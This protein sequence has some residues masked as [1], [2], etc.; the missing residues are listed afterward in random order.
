MN[1]DLDVDEAAARWHMAQDDDAMDWDGFTRW[2][3]ADPR[4]RTAFDAIALLD[5]KIDAALPDLRRIMPP[6]PAVPARRVRPLRWAIGGSAVA[7]VA[8]LGLIFL[9]GT[10]APASIEYRTAQG[11][12]RDVQLADG[13]SAALAPGSVLRA[14]KDRAA[15]LTLDGSASFDV[16]HDPAQP[17]VI[18]AGGYEIRDIGTRFE[19]TTSGDIL[20]VAVSEGRVAVRSPSAE[21]EIDVPAGQVLTVLDSKTAPALTT[22][23]PAA[24]GGW[25]S[26]RLVY[27]DVPLGLVVADI[28][29]STG[30]PVTIDPAIARRRFSGVLATGTRESMVA[31]LSE[32]T[33]LTRRTEENA[34]RLGDRAGR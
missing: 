12:V 29:R 21:G 22:L 27:D 9:P 18:R 28:A 5:E 4:H 32:L 13:S 34:I 17:M 3:E 31:A 16:R 10:P 7:A 24:T 15:P 1:E 11:Q 2:L 30:Q 33:G 8:A 6:E 20:R 14:S 23:R 25:R 19:V 26:G